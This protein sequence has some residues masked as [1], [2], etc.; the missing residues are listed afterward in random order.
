MRRWEPRHAGGTNPKTPSFAKASEG[1]ALQNF[2]TASTFALASSYAEPSTFAGS[3]RF[4]GRPAVASGSD[5]PHFPRPHRLPE[6]LPNPDSPD[7]RSVAFAPF[8]QP[9]GIKEANGCATTTHVSSSFVTYIDE[10]GD[11]GFVF[12]PAGAGSSRWFV[13]SAA[14]IRKSDDLQVVACLREVRALL[15][16][17][18]HQP[19]HF[20]DL[21]H[22][23]R[24][25]YV[26]RVGALPLR[27]VNVLIYKP[28]IAEPARFQRGKD[29]LYRHATRLL[30]ARVSRLCRDQR[31]AGEGDGCT[32]LIFSNRSTMSGAE[33]RAHLSLTGSPAADD[34]SATPLDAQV[35]N[36]GRITTAEHSRLAGLQIA[37]AVA[38]SVY[39]A[40]T[41]NRYGEAEP[42]YLR[43]LAGTIYRSQ[44]Q[45]LEHG[46]ILWPADLAAVKKSAPEAVHLEG[47]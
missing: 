32:D 11:E 34:P 17:P 31:R 20:V 42:A 21:R 26:R 37:D 15:G 33:I 4:Q 9:A 41:R 36:P 12:K 24:I 25:P 8:L 39:L 7:R 29:L 30:L 27:T 28:L 2:A 14:V 38:S 13:L 16:K 22:E 19:L 40:V 10:S 46:L 44:H 1:A 35:I 3:P 47:C 18:P 5:R 6:L 23:Q 45:A 43:L